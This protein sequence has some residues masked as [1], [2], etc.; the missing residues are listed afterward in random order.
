[1][2]YSFIQK[3]TFPTTVASAVVTYLDC[4]HYIF[5]HRSCEQAYK[6]IS[7]E[8]NKCI[9]EIRYKSGIF[10]WSQISTT[11]YIAPA[12]FKQYDVIIR[13]F[14]PAIL[15]GYLL[16]N[17]R[18]TLTYYENDKAIS[19]TDIDTPKKN[20]ELKKED[21]IVISEIKYEMDIPFFLFMFR[22][23]IEK[24]LKAMKIKKD[25]EDLYMIRRRIMLFGDD[26]SLEKDCEYWKPYFKKSYFLLFKENFF[27]SFF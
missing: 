5:L 13:G 9:S 21:R 23:Y 14:G 25:S 22:G 1:M 8:G 26:K 15:A 19:I 6:I 18:T 16:K 27:K 12:Q 10:S 2:Y 17:I 20:I 24:K 7:I 4:E 11:E 3:Y